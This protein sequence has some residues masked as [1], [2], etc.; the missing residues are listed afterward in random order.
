MDATQFLLAQQ[1]QRFE[2]DCR[3]AQARVASART[4]WEVTRAAH[5]VPPSLL[6]GVHLHRHGTGQQQLAQAAFKRMEAL[7]SAQLKEAADITDLEAR[8]A[9]LGRLRLREWDALRG[10]FAALYRKA[11]MEG[12]RLL[13]NP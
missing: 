4:M 13:A 7:L 6:R 10:E 5:V 1:A 8:K 12:R 3:S 9:F 11:D 2:Q